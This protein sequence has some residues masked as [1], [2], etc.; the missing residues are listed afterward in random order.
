VTIED[1]AMQLLCSYKWPGN[2]RELEG[3]IQMLLMATIGQSSITA[4]A[5]RDLL[6]DP[7]YSAV[8]PDIA[9]AP[10]RGPRIV[11]PKDGT[12]DILPGES[13][14]E[15]Y[16]RIDRIILEQTQQTCKTRAAAATRLGISLS[17]F[18]KAMRRIRPARPVEY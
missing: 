10:S 1:D 7:R 5:V 13:R 8:V 4:K 6:R 18:K 11:M 2:V 9:P 3:K 14:K 17:A 12:M 15:W 16:E